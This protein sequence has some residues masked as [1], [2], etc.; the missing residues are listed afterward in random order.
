MLHMSKLLL[1]LNPRIFERKK[2]KGIDSCKN[3]R[4]AKTIG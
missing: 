1:P 2:R 3:E 4:N